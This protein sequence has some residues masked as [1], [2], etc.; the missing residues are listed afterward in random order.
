MSKISFDYSLVITW[1]YFITYVLVFTIAS[2]VCAISVYKDKEDK[3]VVKLAKA[4]AKSIWVKKKIYLELV[5]HFFDQATDFGVVYEFYISYSSGVEIGINM[6]YLFTLSIAIIVTHRVVSAVAVYNLTHNPKYAVAQLFDVLMIQC[7]YTNYK[8][9]TAEPSNAQRYLKTMEAIFE[10]APELLLQATYLIKTAQTT[11]SLTVVASLLMS[12]WSLSSTVSADDK[13]M[14]KE[15]WKSV[16]FKDEDDKWTFPFVNAKYVIRVG[17]WRFL[18]ISSRIT[19]LV[20]TWINLGGK[21]IFFLLGIEF[22][23]L[24]LLSWALGTIDILANLIYLMVAST[25]GKRYRW[26]KPMLWSFWIWR[27]FSGWALLITITVYAAVDVEYGADVLNNEAG[28]TRFDQTFKNAGLALFIYAWV[29]TPVW[30]WVGAIVIF[31]YGNLASVGRDVDTLLDDGKYD[32]VLELI[33]FGASFDAFAVL[34]KI[35]GI[36][37]VTTKDIEAQVQAE[38][39]PKAHPKASDPEKPQPPVRT[40]PGAHGLT[41]FIYTQAH[42]QR[43]F[44]CSVCRSHGG[45]NEV[46][47]GCRRCDYDE[48]TRCNAKTPDTIPAINPA[49]AAAKPNIVY[50]RDLAGANCPGSHGLTAFRTPQTGYSCNLCRTVCRAHEVMHGC[51]SCNYDLCDACYAKNTSKKRKD[52][53]VVVCDRQHE[54]K[55]KNTGY[56]GGYGTVG[57]KCNLCRAVHSGRTAWHCDPC[58]YD[59]CDQCYAAGIEQTKQLKQTKPTEPTKPTKPSTESDST[60]AKARARSVSRAK[61]IANDVTSVQLLAKICRQEIAHEQQNAIDAETS[62]EAKV[63]KFCDRMCSCQSFMVIMAVVLAAIGTWN[64]IVTDGA[65]GYGFYLIIIAGV[66]ICCAISCVLNLF[67]KINDCVPTEANQQK[68]VEKQKSIAANDI[69][70]PGNHG[71]KE[72][73]AEKDDVSCSICATKVRINAVVYGCSECKYDA[74]ADCKGSVQ[75]RKQWDDSVCCAKNHPLVKDE[76]EDKEEEEHADKDTTQEGKEDAN[77]A[78][79]MHK[80]NKCEQTYEEQASWYCK[81]CDYRLCLACFDEEQKSTQTEN[82]TWGGD[83]LE[84]KPVLRNGLIAWKYFFILAF[85]V[86]VDIVVMLINSAHACDVVEDGSV[87]GNVSGFLRDAPSYHMVIIGL[88]ACVYIFGRPRLGCREAIAKKADKYLMWIEGLYCVIVVFY[89][90]VFYGQMNEENVVDDAPCRGSV[91]SWTIFRLIEFVI[92]CIYTYY[93]Q[94]GRQCSCGSSAR[95]LASPNCPG[96]HGLTAFRTPQSGYAC[97]VCRKTCSANEVMHGC[98]TCNYDLCNACYAKS[99][100]GY[101][102]GQANAVAMARS[103]YQDQYN[104]LGCCDRMKIKLQIG[105]YACGSLDQQLYLICGC[106]CGILALGLLI[107][108]DIAVIAVDSEVT[109]D[110]EMIEEEIDEGY[111]SSLVFYGATMH[112]VV[113]IFACCMTMVGRMSQKLLLGLMCCSCIYFIMWAISGFSIYSDMDSS[114]PDNKMCADAIVSWSILKIVEFVVLPLCICLFAR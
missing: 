108:P 79:K 5:P 84:T 40:C 38:A 17:F 43:R 36:R 47:H 70:C 88:R 50:A 46:W 15:E 92:I 68:K 81:Q 52:E 29:A 24:A 98:R 103:Q 8:L 109:C 21:A 90:F 62:K 48:C 61:S 53:I 32:Q 31:D 22:C 44:Y 18:E 42:A 19:L 65:A 83:G 37:N 30:Q 105:L 7:I 4:W 77:N 3:G 73:K 111:Y 104:D 39:H 101:P 13:T 69:D 87:S 91:L 25:K 71:L 55:K 96:S 12:L 60:A 67:E 9:G 100:G 106:F 11:I 110:N 20:L 89:G 63:R 102:S 23:Y 57:Y 78:Y 86:G 97:N 16:Q 72:Y 75:K 99:T 82:V 51:R 45:V 49:Y 94:Q 114:T 27:V 2:I 112:I 35:D 76:K 1:G 10:S 14:L 113:L 54:L 6:G 58:R 85:L 41:P 64:V 95:D 26:A 59:L 74:C 33:S 56:H 28:E 80:C 107:G 66:L 34:Q 93:T